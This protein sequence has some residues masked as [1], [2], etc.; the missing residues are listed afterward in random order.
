MARSVGLREPQNQ[1]QGEIAGQ[2]SRW[3]TSDNFRQTKVV[4]CTDTL[5]FSGF[6]YCTYGQRLLDCLNEGLSG[7]DLLAGRYFL[8]LTQVEIFLPDGKRANAAAT[9]IR[10]SNILFVTGKEESR[11][12]TSCTH[13]SHN[14]YPFKEKVTVEATIRVAS[15][16]V[17]GKMHNDVW[18]LLI[19]TLERDEMFLPITSVEISPELANGKRIFRFVAVN[20]DRIT[21]VAK[22]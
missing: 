21:Y 16:T 17:T 8:P 4:V 2:D 20:K 19:D 13:P 1:R 11:F 10:K 5:I 22:L 14:T 12:A 6:T 15:Y 18:G 9:Y 3:K 7:D